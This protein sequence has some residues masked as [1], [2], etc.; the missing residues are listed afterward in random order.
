MNL[1]TIFSNTPIIELAQVSIR[2]RILRHRVPTFKEYALRWLR[3]Q[4]QHVNFWALKDISFTVDA[5]EVIGIIGANGAGKSTL[6][7]VIANILKP[8]TGE[9]QVRGVVAPI[10]SLG[11]GFDPEMTGRENVYLNGAMFGFSRKEMKKRMPKLLEFSGLKDFID[12]PLRTYSSGMVSRL[13]FSIAT[14]VKPD[15]LLID[16]VLSVGDID[17]QQKCNARIT[18]YKDNGTTTVIVSHNLSAIKE[19]CDRVIWLEHGV[20]RMIG[21]TTSLIVDAYQREDH[22]SLSIVQQVKDVG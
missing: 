7:K 12:A 1:P 9:I 16:E 2:Y 3:N 11:A 17:F 8:V 10:L 18:S 15:I 5:G 20:I 19:L 21:D 22:R 4:N 6:L 14:D 13:A